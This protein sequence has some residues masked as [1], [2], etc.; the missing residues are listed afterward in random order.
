MLIS[1]LEITRQEELSLIQV[2]NDLLLTSEQI[3]SDDTSPL[4]GR[5]N[6]RIPSTSY[7]IVFNI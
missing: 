3:E 4:L 5:I 1:L 6:K 2:L 7:I